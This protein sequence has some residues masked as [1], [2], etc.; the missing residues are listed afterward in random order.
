MIKVI[1]YLI[2]FIL[3]FKGYIKYIES[4]SIFFP[5]QEIENTPSIFGLKYEDIFI[6]APDGIKL[7]AWFIPSEGSKYTLLFFHGNAGNISTRLDKIQILNS[8]NTNVFIVDYRGY[9]LSEG[10]SNEKNAY[11]D[12]EIAYDYLINER[13]LQPSNIIVYGESLGGAM[14]VDLAAKKKIKGIIL[15]GTFSSGTDMGRVIYPFIPRFLFSKI[16]DSIGKIR[17]IDVPKLVIHSQEDEVVPFKLG[18]K[19]FDS[20]DPPKQF[21]KI[22]GGHNSA[23]LDSQDI[24]VSA[25]AAFLKSLDSDK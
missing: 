15:E 25:I 21:V 13:K 22:H 8:I 4:K 20:A 17:Q 11:T 2:G 23:F 19:L 1:V 16:L 10:K 18:K 9:G 6:P 12:A 24:Y 5:S 3:L 14:A 7:N